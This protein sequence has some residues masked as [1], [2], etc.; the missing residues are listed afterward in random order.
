MVQ[1][2][3]LFL[4]FLGVVRVSC[5]CTGCSPYASCDEATDSC[6]CKEGFYGDGFN[7]KT[8]RIYS[9]SPADATDRSVCLCEEGTGIA[10]CYGI[11]DQYELL[12]SWTILE[13]KHATGYYGVSADTLGDI[14]GDGVPDVLIGSALELSD[15]GDEVGGALITWMNSDGS[16]QEQKKLIPGYG[17]MPDDIVA[18]Q[19]SFG[20][21]VACFTKLGGWPLCGIGAP[22]ASSTVD[23]TSFPYTG[24][25]VLVLFN[26]SSSISEA[27]LLN[28]NDIVEL[29][30]DYFGVSISTMGDLDANG[31]GDLVVGAP[32][33]QDTKV[34][35]G[36]VVIVYISE[37]GGLESYKIIH[38]S[39]AGL[40]LSS[41]SSFG[42]GVAGGDFNGD[43]LRDVAVGCPLCDTSVEDDDSGAIY[44]LLLGETQDVES[45]KRFDNSTSTLSFVHAG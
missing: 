37:S 14:S 41:F 6:L 4:F 32:G 16:I 43:G 21:A 40:G 24:A 20:Y 45:F 8:C 9:V 19:A 30:D 25:V 23:G 35:Q 31:V 11:N 36:A 44:V 12:D 10:P 15:R 42:Y 27:L 2:F 22:Y 17:G 29:G 39:E 5:E 1:N 13:N 33:Y 7:C 26:S 38:S 18:E 3:C 34:H 28:K